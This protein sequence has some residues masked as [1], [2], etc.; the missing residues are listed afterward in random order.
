MHQRTERGAGGSAGRSRRKLRI[1]KL[2]RNF[3]PNGLPA[4]FLLLS[5]KRASEPL[6]RFRA[7][8]AGTFT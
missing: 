7:V 2:A 3:L 4:P 1:D 5:K 6:R 8:P